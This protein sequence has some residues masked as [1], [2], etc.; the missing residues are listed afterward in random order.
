VGFPAGRVQS[1]SGLEKGSRPGPKDGA[2][3]DRP[4]H[5]K[6]VNASAATPKKST[7]GLGSLASRER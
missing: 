2:N 7:T 5:R 4:E 6:G 1:L 3:R